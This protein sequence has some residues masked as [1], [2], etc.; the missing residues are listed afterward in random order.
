MGDEYQDRSSSYLWASQATSLGHGSCYRVD[1]VRR[2]ALELH[3]AHDSW[4]A[5]PRRALRRSVTEVT[6]TTGRN[7]QA[8]ICSSSE[9]NVH[10]LAQGCRSCHGARLGCPL[11]VP[12][13]CAQRERPA[14][15][16]SAHFAAASGSLRRVLVQAGRRA[17]EMSHVVE[18]RP[19]VRT[20]GVPPS[21]PGN[22]TQ[23]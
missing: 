8:R 23:G 13:R 14:V 5:S 4:P 1:R 10:S 15:D 20:A 21:E 22:A 11:P 12:D 6:S 17:A 19:L 3:C 16:R 7:R 18:V 9:R 2:H